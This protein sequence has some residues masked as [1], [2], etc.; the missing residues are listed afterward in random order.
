[1]S[2]NEQTYLRCQ[3]MLTQGLSA[4][5]DQQTEAIRQATGAVVSR[6]AL[7]RAAL[8]AVGELE[9]TRFNPR[10]EN[11]LTALLI[12]AVRAGKMTMGW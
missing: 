9:L 10:N 8:R 2:E 4:L 5:L 11:D 12:L 3:L 7:V 6:S 1:M